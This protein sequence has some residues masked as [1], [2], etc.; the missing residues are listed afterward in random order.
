M[1]ERPSLRREDGSQW[2]IPRQTHLPHWGAGPEAHTL[3]AIT[4]ICVHLR[5]Q[6]QPGDPEGQ[7]AM[8]TVTIRN[9]VL[10]SPGG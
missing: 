7:V 8:A 9:R 6:W 10:P 5:P 4:L 3:F 1:G 2:L